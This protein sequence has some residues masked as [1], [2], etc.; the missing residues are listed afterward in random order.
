VEIE[1]ELY[2]V[3]SDGEFIE[4]DTKISVFEVSGNRIIVKRII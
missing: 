2:E 4:K 1:K 3:E